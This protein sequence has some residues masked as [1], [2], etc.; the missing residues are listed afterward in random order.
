M[1]ATYIAIAVCAWLI[2]V[3]LLAAMILDAKE[4]RDE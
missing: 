3:M 2:M 4:N 1:I